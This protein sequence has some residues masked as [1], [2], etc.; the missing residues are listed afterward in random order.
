[1]QI[2]EILQAHCSGLAAPR[3]RAKVGCHAAC[4]AQ[5]SERTHVPLGRLRLWLMHEQP[6]ETQA[7]VAPRWCTSTVCLPHAAAAST[8]DMAAVLGQHWQ[9]GAC[10][11]TTT[12]NPAEGRP[13][14]TSDCAAPSAVPPA[15]YLYLYLEEVQAQAPQAM[16][17]EGLP[18]SWNV[19]WGHG[20]AGWARPRPRL[21]ARRAGT[22]EQRRA[23][24]R[25]YGGAGRGGWR[26]PAAGQGGAGGAV[27][28]SAGQES[29][30]TNR[31]PWHGTTCTAC[32][33][34]QQVLAR[35]PPSL[36]PTTAAT[37]V[38]A[39]PAAAGGSG[40][41]AGDDEEPQALVFLKWWDPHA[42][43][44]A[45]RYIGSYLVGP[46]TT[47]SGWS[48]GGGVW[49]GVEGQG[50]ASPLEG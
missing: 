49:R 16:H 21:H 19:T 46:R 3:M 26:S 32:L 50:N 41:L 23:P 42:A 5:V 6:R 1:M 24:V 38:P 43:S 2:F 7:P 17:G 9:Y 8:A 27:C 20:R 12:N 28:T 36:A 47:V 13:G 44:E 31:L 18:G 33:P 34:H 39:W 35:P 48:G 10:S 37:A 40:G 30:P 25:P 14:G 4:R 15:A 29:H 11:T 45:P 22:G